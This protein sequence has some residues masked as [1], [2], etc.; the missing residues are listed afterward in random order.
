MN[1][2]V[3]HLMAH[4]IGVPGGSEPAPDTHD[5]IIDAALRCIARVGL[6]KTTLDDVAREAG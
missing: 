6:S 5:R 3:S 2:I 4:Q 1:A